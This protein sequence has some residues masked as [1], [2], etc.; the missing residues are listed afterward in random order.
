MKDNEG[1]IETSL[2]DCAVKRLR[3]FLDGKRLPVSRLTSKFLKSFDKDLADY[4]CARVKYPMCIKRIFKD[5]R[6]EYNDE[7]LDIIIIKDT[8]AKYE[9]EELPVPEKRALDIDTIRKIIQA[10]AVTG[11]KRRDL[12][13][14]CYLISF[15]LMGMNAVDMF[16][17]Q[18][19]SEDKICYKRSK[20]TKRRKD[21]AYIEVDVP[22]EIVP[23]LRKC[24]GRKAAFKYSDM[25]S[26]HA[27]FNATLFYGLKALAKELGLPHFDFY[28]ARHSMA[29][30]GTNEV[31]ISPYVIND[32]LNHEDEKLKVTNMYIKKSFKAINEANRKLIDYVL[33]KGKIKVNV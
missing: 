12:A 4:P 3:K 18:G 23:L 21:D 15:F 6:K 33:K 13:R 17:L 22:R 27:V 31:G 32:M 14:E 1:K 7:D 26:N 2:Y 25:Y 16:K 20:T 29:T 8:L 19:Y 28:S 30:I 9:P 11:R 5:M 10:P 24:K